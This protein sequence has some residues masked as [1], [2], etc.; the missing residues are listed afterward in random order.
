MCREQIEPEIGE[1]PVAFVARS[2]GSDISEDDIKQFVSKEVLA[3]STLRSQNLKSKINKK[4]EE[5]R[6]SD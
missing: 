2:Q 4:G 6:L 1:I 5:K 3:S